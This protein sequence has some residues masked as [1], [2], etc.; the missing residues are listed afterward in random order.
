MTIVQTRLCTPEELF[1]VSIKPTVE[2]KPS[3]IYPPFPS[4]M[5]PGGIVKAH[6]DSKGLSTAAWVIIIIGVGVLGGII[7]FENKRRKEDEVRNKNAS[8]SKEY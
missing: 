8:K 4:T 6:V 7:Y 3:I 2:V 1:R 5:Q